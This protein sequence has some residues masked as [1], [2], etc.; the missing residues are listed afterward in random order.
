MPA[1][2][3]H[4]DIKIETGHWSP[5]FH[6]VMR[7]PMPR[8][9]VRRRGVQDRTGSRDRPS[10]AAQGPGWPTC[11]PAR[12]HPASLYVEVT[13]FDGYLPEGQVAIA[14]GRTETAAPRHRGALSAA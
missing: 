10:G 4:H 3:D 12:R 6:Y 13:G 7:K 5:R 9:P 14:A 8:F 2:P 11:H 1:A